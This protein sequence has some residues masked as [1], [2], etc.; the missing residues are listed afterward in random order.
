MNQSANNRS[1]PSEASLAAALAR[2]VIGCGERNTTMSDHQLACQEIRKHRFCPPV[3]LRP[4]LVSMASPALAFRDKDFAEKVLTERM[5]QFGQHFFSIP[6]EQRKKIWLKLEPRVR[7]FPQ[8]AWRLNTL[9]P[10]LTINA[11]VP[12]EFSY[13]SDL[14]Q[15]TCDIFVMTPDAAGNSLRRKFGEISGGGKVKETKKALANFASEY[16][17]IAALR[18]AG[19]LPIAARAKRATSRPKRNP[20]QPWYENVG[21]LPSTGI[22]AVAIGIL[23]ILFT[24]GMPLIDHL[25]QSERTKQ[26]SLREAHERSMDA[27]FSEMRS[28]FGKIESDTMRAHEK[29]QEEVGKAREQRRE[30]IQKVQNELRERGRQRHEELKERDK[31][32]DM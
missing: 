9:K 17:E 12:N 23:C 25:N 27:T 5:E 3:K 15:H 8:L 16:P 19:V 1:L 13:G 2:R 29:R 14:A 6:I 18:P 22:V 11:P 20:Q 7:P 21:F 32:I 10:G 31:G 26:E 28:A 24:Y 30:S 4:P